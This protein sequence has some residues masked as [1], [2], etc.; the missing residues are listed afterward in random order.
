MLYRP[1]D[2]TL[3]VLYKVTVDWIGLLDLH[4]VIRSYKVVKAVERPVGTFKYFT[5]VSLHF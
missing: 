2:A 4:Y 3:P 1:C 5:L